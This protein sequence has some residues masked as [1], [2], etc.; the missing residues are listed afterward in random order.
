MPCDLLVMGVRHRLFF[1]S[2]VLGS[3]TARVVRHA[4]CPVLTVK[5][6]AV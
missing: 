4:P 3:T 2:T 5:A 6:K 1:D